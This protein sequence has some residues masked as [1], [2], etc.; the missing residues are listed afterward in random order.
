MGCGTPPNQAE[1]LLRVDNREDYTLL[2]TYTKGKG[3]KQ[4]TA[5]MVQDKDIF[6]TWIYN[7]YSAD[8]TDYA[9][10]LEA[11]RDEAEQKM[12][13]HGFKLH[14]PIAGARIETLTI[15]EYEQQLDQTVDTV[16]KATQE[17]DQS[18]Y[19]KATLF[20]K[21]EAEGLVLPNLR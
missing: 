3:K 11:Q 8:G 2:G 19:T 14:E 20:D 15:D 17:A 12:L 5:L 16:V 9:Y 18:E 1:W 6:S 10:F 21:A 7:V 13:S 4:K